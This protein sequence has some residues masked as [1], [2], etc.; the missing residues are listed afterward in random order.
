MFVLA[1]VRLLVSHNPFPGRVKLAGGVDI[2]CEQ[3]SPTYKLLQW[4]TPLKKLFCNKQTHTVRHLS[5]L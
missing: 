4:H 3:S 1:H 5:K 2:A